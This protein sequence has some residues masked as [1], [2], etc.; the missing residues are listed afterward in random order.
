MSFATAL[1]FAALFLIGCSETVQRAS[2][3]GAIP[4]PGESVEL[5]PGDNIII[6]V[7]SIPDPAQTQVQI[8]DQ[9][10][11]TLRY[12]GRIKASGLTESQLAKQIRATYIEKKIY[13]TVDISVSV[14]QR[15]VYVG[16]EVGRSGRV[17]WSPDLTLTKAIQSAGGFS[18]YAD[19]KKVSLNRDNRSYN[20]NAKEAQKRPGSDPKLYPGDSIN[21]KRSAL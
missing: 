14:T 9:G 18:L 13:H 16:G 10:F 7:H 8:D 1:A 17:E 5:R 21:V 3:S 6:D 19:K 11:V 15:F 4:A 2:Q 20:I 12:I